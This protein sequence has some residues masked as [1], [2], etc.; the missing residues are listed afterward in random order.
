MKGLV[1]GSLERKFWSRVEIIPFH[2]CWEWIGSLNEEGYGIVTHQENFV[3][4]SWPAHRLSLH[5]HGIV[6][7]PELVV[8]HI[9]RNRT[10]VNPKHLRMV[11]RTINSKE[12]TASVH[13][14]C[15]KGHI[16][17][18]VYEW[19]GAKFKY[20]TTCDLERK[21]IWYQKKKLEK[22]NK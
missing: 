11:T 1:R 3:G 7:D 14:T 10:C 17:D 6:L 22:L 9:C 2:P 5:L 18:R 15:L 4:K 19:R 21:K 8:D 20:C 13:S 16:H 12:N